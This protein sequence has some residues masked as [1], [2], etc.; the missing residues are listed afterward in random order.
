MW[1]MSDEKPTR[2]AYVS[3]F[4]KPSARDWIDTLAREHHTSR[5]EVIRIALALAKRHES[6]FKTLLTT[7]GGI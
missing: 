4:I 1:S 6:E 7:T 2:R 5:S 3:T